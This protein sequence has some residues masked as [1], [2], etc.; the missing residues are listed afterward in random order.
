MG[1]GVPEKIAWYDYIFTAI[2]IAEPIYVFLR[3]DAFISTGF[4]PNMVDLVMGTLLVIL[5][6]EAT[7]RISG[8]ALPILCIIF[9]LYGMFGRY[10][11][12]DLFRHR[13]YTWAAIMKNKYSDEFAGAVVATASVGG[14]LMPPIMGAAA[15]ASHGLLGKV[16]YGGYMKSSLCTMLSMGIAVVVYLILVITLGMIT[17][18]DLRMVPHGAKLAKILHL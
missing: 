4:K 2:A 12:I 1:E 9:L 17:R 7:R 10:V 13:G 16:L 15:W 6:L 8:A 14:Q 5:V 11:P 18:E 3:Y